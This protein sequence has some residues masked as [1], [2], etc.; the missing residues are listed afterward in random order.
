MRPIPFLYIFSILIWAGCNISQNTYSSA[1][2]GTIQHHAAFA[3]QY[4]DARNVDIWLPPNYDKDVKKTYSVLIMHDGQML[5]DSTTTWNHQEWGVDE[6]AEKLI[7]SGQTEPFV[8]VGVWNTPKRFVEY[9]PQQ[10]ALTFPDSLV[11]QL[12]NFKKADFQADN[13][14][15]FLT[16]EL[17]PFIEKNYRVKTDKADRYIMGSS[18][19]GLISLYAI[20]QYP[21]V[22]GG[23]ACLS[24]HW[25]VAFSND[26]IILPN[27]LINYF[28]N[29]LPDPK[30]HQ[31][32][33]D[34]GTTTLDSLYEPHQLR[35]DAVMQAA[36]YQ[37]GKN[38]ATRKFTGA[39]HSEKAWRERLDI[40]LKFLLGSK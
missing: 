35:M 18:M 17:I 34:Y 16:K 4:V 25:P 19:G 32:Y 2:R 22:F 11:N 40:P 8:V 12:R 29:H 26:H 33:F 15:L 39:D 14:L 31:I 1:T 6:T 27:T 9:L 7:Q 20:C 3:S 38:W 37:Q 30:T 13:Y 23:A 36:G 5:Y 24:T 28:A 10:P 21:D